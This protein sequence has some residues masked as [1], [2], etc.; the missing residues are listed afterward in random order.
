MLH[1]ETKLNNYKKCDIDKRV[2]K[3]LVRLRK[4]FRLSQRELAN[5]SGVSYIGQIESGHGGI[6]KQ[7][8]CKL[9]E[10]LNIDPSEFYAPEISDSETI[11]KI[12]E[13]CKTLSVEGQALVLELVNDLA[14][15]EMRLKWR[16]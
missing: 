15:Y 3:N 9:A 16:E 6:G 2:R 7:V 10:T 1:Y 4:Q 11:A 5:L 12:A 13:A 14:A 8:V